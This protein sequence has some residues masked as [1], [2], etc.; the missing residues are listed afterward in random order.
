VTLKLHAGAWSFRRE[1]SPTNAG[2]ICEDSR[3]PDLLLRYRYRDGELQA[4][5]PMRVVQDDA[6]LVTW[7][8]PGTQIMYWALQNGDDPRSVPLDERFTQ[9]L[10]TAPREWQGNGVLRVMSVDEPF[11]VLHFWDDG[12]SFAGWYVNFEAPR[13]RRSDRVD[14]VDWHLDLR[15]DPDGTP[16]WK[17]ED[18]ADAAVSAGH[19]DQADLDLARST[20]LAILHD[21]PAWLDA[22]GDWRS[23]RRASG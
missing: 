2:H 7:L 13:R 12:G 19:L 16:T 3:V 18:E 9:A 15:I 1:A 14:S 22:L 5:F 20:G 21:F 6:T 4:A 11:Q 23:F 17:D 8:A 10:T